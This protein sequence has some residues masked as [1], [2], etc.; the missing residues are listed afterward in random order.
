MHFDLEITVNRPIDEVFRY[1]ADI[2]HVPE[3]AN[4]H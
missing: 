3:W 4:R 1:A 2:E